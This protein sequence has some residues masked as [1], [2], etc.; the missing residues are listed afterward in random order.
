MN[1]TPARISRRIMALSVTLFSV[2]L[3]AWMAAAPATAA[4]VLGRNTTPN[5]TRSEQGRVVQ[6]AVKPLVKPSEHPDHGVLIGT[7]ASTAPSTLTENT[8]DT[9]TP[10]GVTCSGGRTYNGSSCVCPT[11]TWNGMVCYSPPLCTNVPATAGA[12]LMVC[13]VFPPGP[14]GPVG[15]GGEFIP[16]DQ[17]NTNPN[18]PAWLPSCIGPQ[19]QNMLDDPQALCIIEFINSG[20]LELSDLQQ[21]CG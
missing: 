18:D 12:P 20:G 1:T 6:K 8:P 2:A 11:G 21:A 4:E 19:C 3:A 7:S 16:E 5:A 15:P 13:P 17:P 10:T 14:T 9:K